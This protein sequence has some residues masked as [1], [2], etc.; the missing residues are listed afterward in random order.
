MVAP[1][2][3]RNLERFLAVLMDKHDGAGLSP[4]IILLIADARAQWAELD[5]R[6]AAF[7]AQFVCWAKQNEEVRR[8][9]RIPALARSSPRLSLPPSVKRKAST[10]GAILRRGSLPP[11]PCSIRITMRPLSMSLT[12]SAATSETHSLAA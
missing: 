7:D 10:A 12:F 3:K 8:L 4:R 11:L 1:Q 5:R 2:G 9:A 6:T